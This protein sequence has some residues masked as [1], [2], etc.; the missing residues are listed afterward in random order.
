MD[1]GYQNFQDKRMAIFGELVRRYWKG[2][3]SSNF[4][5]DQLAEEMKERFEFQDK[6]LSFIR[7]QIRVA[8]GLDPQGDK[9]FEDELDMIRQSKT[10]KNPVIAKISGP[11]EHCDR[12]DCGAYEACKYEAVIYNRNEGPVVVEDQCLSCGDCTVGC[13]FGALMDKIEFM[14]MIELLKNKEQ[15]VFAVVAPAIAGQFGEDISMGKLRTA[16]KTMGFSDMIEVAM[17]ADILTI[18][19]AFEFIHLVKEQED[20]FLTSCCCPI[21]FNMTKKSFTSLYDHMSPS[22]SPMIASGRILK[23]LYPDSKI[24]FFSPC[25]AKKS[26][27]KDGSLQGAIDSVINFME[28]KEIFQ[29]LDIDLAGLQADEKDQGSIAGRLYARSGGVSFSVKTIVNRLAPKRL[30]KLKP[31]RVS[32]AL[33]CKEILRKISAGEFKE[34]NF[35]EGMGCK[36]GCVGGPKTNLDVDQSLGIVNDYA[37]DS[38]IM[39]P[40]DNINV[41]KILRQLGIHDIKEIV[42][43]EEIGKML[44]RD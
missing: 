20:F 6:D 14:P 26:E 41:M 35:I 1:K 15:K 4:D 12:E 31:K 16:F 29:A 27:M 9:G 21:W 17:F 23:T 22:V 42:E 39:T 13:D 24:V 36:G 37:E 32:G 30:I 2:E 34:G 28:L 18:K 25:V 3:I 38:I 33:E 8:M 19:E 40:F 44:T 7:D 5:L 43:N 11:C 10:I